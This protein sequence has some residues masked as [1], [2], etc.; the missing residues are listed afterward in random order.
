MSV[1]LSLNPPRFQQFSDC[2]HRGVKPLI[3]VRAKIVKLCLEAMQP[4]RQPTF[5]RPNI[6]PD[7]IRQIVQLGLKAVDSLFEPMQDRAP[8][9]RLR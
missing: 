1:I 2:P 3:D 4:A 8:R 9:P 6:D 5:A 7:Q